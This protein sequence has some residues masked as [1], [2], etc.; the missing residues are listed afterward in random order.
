MS[1]SVKWALKGRDSRNDREAISN[2]GRASLQEITLLTVNRHS[3]IIVLSHQ[4]N[5]PTVFE[6]ISCFK[7]YSWK[8][9][10]HCM[11]CVRNEWKMQMNVFK[12]Y[13]QNL[14]TLEDPVSRYTEICWKV[15]NKTH[16]SESDHRKIVI[17]FFSFQIQW[18][19]EKNWG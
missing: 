15:T 4:M 8:Q 17:R 12:F 18:E 1:K 5:G 19:N 2:Y 11:C 16:K 10:V 7:K 6:D 13:P 14:E 9:Y 3:R